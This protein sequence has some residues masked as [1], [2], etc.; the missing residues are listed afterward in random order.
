[1]PMCPDQLCGDCEAS[2][3]RGAWGL[4]RFSRGRLLQQVFF[5]KIHQEFLKIFP[6][7]LRVLPRSLWAHWQR[8]R[9]GFILDWLLLSAT[10]FSL[11][12]NLH[13]GELSGHDGRP[14]V[15]VSLAGA[16][17]WRIS[18][19][20]GGDAL[21]GPSDMSRSLIGCYLRR[22]MSNTRRRW[23]YPPPSTSSPCWSGQPT[24]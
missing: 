11:I 4:H 19:G 2:P 22:M 5:P 6:S 14:Q 7:E 21:I 10:F 1:M 17:L 23:A 8:L 20:W 24:S 12:Q 3:G 18:G 13:G 16:R 9:Q 15:W